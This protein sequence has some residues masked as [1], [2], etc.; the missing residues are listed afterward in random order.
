MHP[1]LEGEE[2]GGVSYRGRVQ[3]TDGKGEGVF[4]LVG[5]EF[6]GGLLSFVASCVLFMNMNRGP[7]NTFKI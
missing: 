5:E 7:T 3:V 2:G 1:G 6:M 4:V